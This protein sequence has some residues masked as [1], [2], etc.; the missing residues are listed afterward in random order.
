M[1]GRGSRYFERGY[2]VPK[3]LL[4][5][6]GLSMVVQAANC[7]P[8]CQRSVFVCLQEHVEK[9]DLKENQAGLR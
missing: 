2:D 6:N 5:I 1:A 7:L 3:P 8:K 4:D 9:F